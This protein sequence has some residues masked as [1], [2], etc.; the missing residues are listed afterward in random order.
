M[1]YLVIVLIL[2]SAGCTKPEAKCDKNFDW[3]QIEEGKNYY[4]CCDC[5]L[6]FM[7][8]NCI[9]ATTIYCD[10]NKNPETVIFEY[11]GQMYDVKYIPIHAGNY[12]RFE[13]CGNGNCRKQDL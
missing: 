13:A 11:E 6:R 9:H 2:I 1:K 3:V 5:T 12:Y 8:T 7:G 4:A 10:K